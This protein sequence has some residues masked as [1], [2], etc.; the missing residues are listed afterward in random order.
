MAIEFRGRV[1]PVEDELKMVLDGGC[2]RGW[3]ACSGKREGEIKMREKKDKM[4]ILLN[5]FDFL[6]KD[7]HGRCQVRRIPSYI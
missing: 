4:V 1:I 7:H 6:I 2:Q 3:D 5:Y